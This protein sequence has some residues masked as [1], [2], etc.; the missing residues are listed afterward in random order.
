[1]AENT[2][3]VNKDK[4]RYW[5]TIGYIESLDEDWKDILERTGLRVAISPLHDKDIYDKDIKNKET[6]E[7]LY[8]KGDTKKAHYHI[9]LAWDNATTYNSAK[10][11]CDSIGAVRPEPV[12]RIKGNY[13]YLTHKYSPKKAQYNEE[14]IETLNGFNIDDFSELL[15]DEA[16]KL[17]NAITHLIV[18]NGISEYYS[19]IL[20]LETYNADLHKYASKHTYF[21]NTFINSFRYSYLNTRR[22]DLE[23]DIPPEIAEE[24]EDDEEQ[25]ENGDC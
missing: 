23:E 3:K 2:Q 15:E 21:F 9:I 10:S 12:K 14:D 11:L 4:Y 5:G 20:F 8:K 25:E 22:S 17:Q 6:G 18:E 19:L 13:A 1:M 7:I 16:I 24:I